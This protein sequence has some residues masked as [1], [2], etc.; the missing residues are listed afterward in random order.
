MNKEVN[1]KRGSNLQPSGFDR[2]ASLKIK[3]LNN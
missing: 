3:A 1:N 2:Q